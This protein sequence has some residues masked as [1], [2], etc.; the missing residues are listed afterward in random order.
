[1]DREN[2]FNLDLGMD[3]PLVEKMLD[4]TATARPSALEVVTSGVWAEYLKDTGSSMLA[5][6]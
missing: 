6:G 1:M 5:A 3:G 2:L 4:P